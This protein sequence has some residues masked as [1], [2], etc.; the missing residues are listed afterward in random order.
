MLEILG[1]GWTLRYARWYSNNFGGSPGQD[2]FT[3]QWSEVG[4]ADWVNL[5][6]IGPSG[7]GT[8]G[9]WFE[10][11]F[12]LDDVG[13]TG[14]EAFQLRVIADDAGDGSVIEAG[15]DAISL[16]RFT[17]ED[18]NGCNGD[19]DGNGS[20][21]VNDILSVIAVY[22]SDDGSGDANGDGTVDISD[23]L[24]IISNWGPC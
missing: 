7:A 18:G 14:I 6:L 11:S 1:D 2:L 15:L 5:E 13:L 20:V 4:S 21:N 3:V 12:E 16:A 19:V 8:T 24:L 10:V 9:G 23:I 22:G 17:C